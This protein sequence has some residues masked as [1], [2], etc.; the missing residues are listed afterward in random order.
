MNFVSFTLF[1]RQHARE[2]RAVGFTAKLAVLSALQRVL[3]WRDCLLMS[4][5]SVCVSFHM[6]FI[7]PVS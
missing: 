7:K 5:F 6:P 4:A 2:C 1:G 3:K